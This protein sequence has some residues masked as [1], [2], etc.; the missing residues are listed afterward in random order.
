M[1]HLLINNEKYLTE[2]LSKE[3]NFVFP[4]LVKS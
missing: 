2:N 3:P 1:L 4:F